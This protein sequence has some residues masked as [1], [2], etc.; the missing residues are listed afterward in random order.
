MRDLVSRF[1]ELSLADV[2]RCGGTGPAIYRR[3]LLAVFGAPLS[4]EDHVR[5]ALLTAAG[6]QRAIG[7]AAPGNDT[8]RLDLQVPDR[9]SYRARRVWPNR[10]G[11]PFDRTVIGD[12]ANVAARL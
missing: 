9:C 2:E 10:R 5:R 3:W 4:H 7:G 12:A 11:L 6:I 8:D 1:L